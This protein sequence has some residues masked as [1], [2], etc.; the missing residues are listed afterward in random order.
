MEYY[1]RDE[2]YH[3]GV[4]G[5]RWCIRRF[6]NEDGSLTPAG[7]KRYGEH[8]SEFLNT[9]KAYKQ[10]HRNA[11]R[12]RR[13]AKIANIATKGNAGVNLAANIAG[14]SAI[15]P[16]AR[17]E[18]EAKD[19]YTRAKFTRDYETGRRKKLKGPVQADVE[20]EIKYGRRESVRIAKRQ[21][22]GMTRERA[23]RISKNKQTAR[24]IAGIA[25]SGLGVY[26]QL[27]GGKVTEAAFKGGAKVAKAVYK[28]AKA[29]RSVYNNHYNAQ[30]LDATGKV[31]AR[32]HDAAE[33]GEIAVRGLLKA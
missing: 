26:N 21:N 9:K 24:T 3:Y 32:Y 25:V 6:Q 14:A 30:I 23:E 12:V 7:V 5:Q 22:K 33:W 18:K 1:R 29:A 19:N 10:A 13:I 20:D 4:K 16:Y 2:L 27:S 28:G 15:S 17:K 8:G 11:N 31:V